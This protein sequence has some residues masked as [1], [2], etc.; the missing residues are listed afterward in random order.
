MR[1]QAIPSKTE[2]STV[3]FDKGLLDHA[4]A[5][6]WT[7]GRFGQKVVR[8]RAFAAGD[9]IQYPI[10]WKFGVVVAGFAGSDCFLRFS[11][12]RGADGQDIDTHGDN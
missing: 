2:D 9:L 4:A 7:A 10:E 3:G 6:A 1:R 11:N 8:G 5:A 12:G